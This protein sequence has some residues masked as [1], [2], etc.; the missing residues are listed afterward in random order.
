MQERGLIQVVE[1][2]RDK[3]CWSKQYEY[4]EMKSA[5]RSLRKMSDAEG[6][7]EGKGSAR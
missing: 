5:N 7:S 4:I 2:P 1:N 3:Y 6:M